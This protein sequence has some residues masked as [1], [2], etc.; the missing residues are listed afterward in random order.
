MAFSLAGV[1]GRKQ[2]QAQPS[3]DRGLQDEQTASEVSQGSD[4]PK[5]PTG[6]VMNQLSG[7]TRLL[8]DIK[9]WI[10]VFNPRQAGIDLFELMSY[11]PDIAFG[12][13][14]LRAPI[15][16]MKHQ[17]KSNDPIVKLFV[18]HELG[19]WYRQCATTHSLAIMYGR[20]ASE[21]I[22][23]SGP[24]T[25]TETAKDGTQTFKTL[26]M[27]WTY[28]KFKGLDP[29]LIN[30]LI[31]PERDEWSGIEQRV[32]I[33][34]VG[35][36]QQRPESQHRVGTEKSVLW[37][38]RKEEVWGKLQG[39]AML[40]QAYEPWWWSAAM[41]LFANRYFERRA[42]PAFKAWADAVVET[43]AGKKEDGFQFILNALMGLRGGGVA[44]LPNLKDH[45]GNRKFDFELLMDDK[46]GDMFQQR[47][48]WLSLQKLRALWITDKAGTSDGTG[49]QAMATVHQDTM[50]MMM[51]AIT[52][53]WLAVLNEQI[54]KP[55]VVYNFGQ[56][57][58][59]KSKTQVVAGGMDSGTKA[60]MMEVMKALAATEQM[61]ESGETVT[62]GEMIDGPALLKDI[63]MPIHTPDELEALGAKKAEQKQAEMDA[64]AAG[65][66]PSAP[67]GPDEKAIAADLASRGH[68]E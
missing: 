32:A 18:E 49:S 61:L 24:V 25:M 20:Q 62:L 44:V 42:D 41:N 54:I 5:P 53:E 15:V 19:R 35:G 63:G 13:A 29:R 9:E 57:V 30:L 31:D 10:G 17:V 6:S 26:P 21:K 46:R 45:L 22:W 55:L 40:K 43:A 67:G 11:D 27:A 37:S 59:E 51:E 66:G 36:T 14:I 16:N 38:F 50:F 4:E 47:I 48:E 58:W 34:Q 28:E 12:S 23:Q 3:Q 33:L 65:K 8:G 56:D 68:L 60:A 2:P 39:K 52:S 7:V 1:F 64:M